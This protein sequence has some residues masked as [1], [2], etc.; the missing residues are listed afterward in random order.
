MAAELVR[1]LNAPSWPSP[2]CL[3]LGGGERW[4][5]WG[6]DH[7][8]QREVSWAAEAARLG[9]REVG[10]MQ[11]L[12]SAGAGRSVST[13][14]GSMTGECPESCS[15]RQPL[16]LLCASPA[17]S[18]RVSCLLFFACVSSPGCPIPAPGA[19]PPPSPGSPGPAALAS[20]VALTPHSLLLFPPRS[21]SWDFGGSA[22]PKIP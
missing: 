8:G 6:K 11:H 16:S 7:A 2:C 4:G 22:S 18:L 13:Q 9:M 1:H 5:C 19:P 14:T 17:V 3:L 21:W 12:E 20:E 10:Q 15:L